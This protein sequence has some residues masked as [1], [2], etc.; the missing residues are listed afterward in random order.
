MSKKPLPP[1]GNRPEPPARP[2]LPHASR[3]LRQ[4][5]VWMSNTDLRAFHEQ[6]YPGAETFYVD[7]KFRQFQADPIGWLSTLDSR[8]LSVVSGLIMETE[9]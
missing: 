3:Y 9:P 5:I 6:I 4:L 2:V 1:V 8:H 7:N